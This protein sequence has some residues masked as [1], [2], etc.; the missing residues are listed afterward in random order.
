MPCFFKK[1]FCFVLEAINKLNVLNGKWDA[2][3]INNSKGDA[4]SNRQEAGTGRSDIRVH[5]TDK[6]LPPIARSIGNQSFNNNQS[7]TSSGDQITL[8]ERQ[9]FDKNRKNAMKNNPFNG[10]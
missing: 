2:S 3:I 7:L 10:I 5:Q 9:K 8:E 6:I 1:I 4:E